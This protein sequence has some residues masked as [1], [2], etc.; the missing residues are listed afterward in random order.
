MG[1]KLCFHQK[2]LVKEKLDKN[3]P[4]TSYKKKSVIG[5]KIPVGESTGDINNNDRVTAL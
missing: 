4:L 2:F 5:L 3:L 1:V